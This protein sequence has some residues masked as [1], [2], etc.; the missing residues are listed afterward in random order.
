MKQMLLPLQNI[1][2]T[3][4]SMRAQCSGQKG[5][6]NGCYS[7]PSLSYNLQ[8]HQRINLNKVTCYCLVV[9]YCTCNGNS[10]RFSFHSL[11][12]RTDAPDVDDDFEKFQKEVTEAEAEVDQQDDERPATTP[13]GEE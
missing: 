8:S 4:I 12:F 9:L 10:V 3:V 6:R 13:D 2:Q 1:L 5:G 7:R 11:N